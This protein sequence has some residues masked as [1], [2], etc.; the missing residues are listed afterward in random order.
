LIRKGRIEDA[1]RAVERLGTKGDNFSAKNTVA[2]MVH[3]D[4]VEK[5]IRSGTSYLDCFRGKINLRRTEIACIT[6]I[7]QQV[8]GSSF[9][10]NSTYFYEQA[11]L[12]QSDSFDMTI[13]QFALGAVG[14]VASWFLMTKVGRRTIYVWGLFT[15]TVILLV[16]GFLGVPHQDSSLSWA[17]GSLLLVYT[18]IYDFTVGPVCYS[19]VAELPS[20]RLRQKTI[21]LARNSYNIVGTA[22][23]NVI[24]LYMLNPTAW[25]WGPKTAF[26]WGGNCLLCFV[27]AY[28]R[29]PE[30]KG[31]TYAE[32]D[33]L[34]DKEVSARKF[35]TTHVDPYEIHS[36]D[37]EVKRLNS[38]NEK[39]EVLVESSG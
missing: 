8:C 25:N 10:G 18:F 24:G 26:F 28:F 5:R 12:A 19:L 32:L 30:P 31:R 16:I 22:Y 11:G 13:A 7:C 29:L 34:F 20:A 37:S 23:T 39:N 15:L 27:W 21:V 35:A 36:S 4:E 1:E 17:V 33:I 9:M 2:F 3:T 14:T 6:W 38:G